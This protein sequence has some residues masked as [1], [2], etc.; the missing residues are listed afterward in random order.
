MTKWADIVFTDAVR[1]AQ[2]KYGTRDF[3]ARLE[4]S[5]R[6]PDLDDN[7]I[8]FIRSRDSIYFGTASADGRPYIQHRGGE[9]GFIKMLNSRTLGFA[10]YPG[11]KQMITTGNL[12]EN[13]QA[14][15]FL[16]DYPSR[17]R[18][19]LWGRADIVDDPDFVKS[20]TEENP[21]RHQSERALRFQVDAWDINCP[22][23]ITP[24]YTEADVARATEMMRNRIAELEAEVEALK[25]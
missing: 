25:A 9:P 20:V 13:P 15:I 14:Y 21:G 3:N 4:A 23:Y 22:K 7:I 11:N 18:I 6:T 10:E 8:A 12:A 2:E 5:E 16:M 17:Q 1:G 24:R 19:K